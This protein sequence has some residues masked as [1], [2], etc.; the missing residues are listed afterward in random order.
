MTAKLMKRPRRRGFFVVYKEFILH[1]I[2][3]IND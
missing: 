2:C 3:A 1:D